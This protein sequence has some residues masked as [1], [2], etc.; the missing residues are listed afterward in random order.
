MLSLPC[1]TKY[2]IGNFETWC[3]I[4]QCCSQLLMLYNLGDLYALSDIFTK[5]FSF[6]RC[7][8]TYMHA[9][10]MDHLC[11]KQCICITVNH[12]LAV[13]FSSYISTVF[14]R[15]YKYYAF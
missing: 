5:Q 3:S 12:V 15:L 10:V 11:A 9:I 14:M 6:F 2:N 4:H 13:C 8:H 1:I 7:V